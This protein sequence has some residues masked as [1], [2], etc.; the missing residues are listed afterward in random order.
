MAQTVVMIANSR[1]Q[2]G[3]N[4][5]RIFEVADYLTSA[6]VEV[7]VI[8]TESSEEGTRAALEYSKTADLIVAAGGDGTVNSVVQG[9][10]EGTA[11]LA[12]AAAGTG[13]D[14]A[15]FLGHPHLRNPRSDQWLRKV[16][17]QLKSNSPADM[18]RAIDIGRVEFG[19]RSTG[20]F[21]TVLSTGFDTRVNERAHRLRK[22]P[23]SIR[24]IIS[25]LV[26]LPQCVAHPYVI[27]ESTRVTHA[28]ALL[29]AVGNS[30]MY[31]RGMR[32]CPE[33]SVFDAEL[34]LTIIGSVSRRTLLRLF[35][36]VFSGQHM[37]DPRVT[38]LQTRSVR[39]SGPSLVC[40]ADGERMGPLPATISV[41]PAVLRVAPAF[42][43]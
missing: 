37:K 11:V 31:G 7:S 41:L 29:V 19:D 4:A 16:L 2:R 20:V 36:S 24:Y 28:S 38:G 9:M 39:I 10:I 26:E 15:R 3:R 32:I 21:V 40:Y 1:L 30:A 25:T 33:A 13:N 17:Q 34:D 5:K 23:G 12:I 22:L 35:P 42:T 18:Q 43:A 6:G 8:F 14:A 27:E